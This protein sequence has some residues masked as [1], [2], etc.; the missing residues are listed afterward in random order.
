MSA[1]RAGTLLGDATGASLDDVS[2]A[3]LTPWRD[4]IRRLDMDLRPDLSNLPVLLERVPLAIWGQVLMA[5]DK[6][7]GRADVY[8]PVM[9]SAAVQEAWTGLSGAPLLRQSIAFIN[10]V[11]LACAEAG[12]TPSSALTLDF[13]VGWGR[14]AMLW[15]KYVPPQRLFGCDAW[16]ESLELAKSARLPIELIQSDPFLGELPV[17][18]G[19][20]DVVYSFSVF[21]SLGDVAF[22]R[23]LEGIAKMLRPG[24]VAL[25]TVR[26]PEYW[27]L[28]PDVKGAVQSAEESDF[29]FRPYADKPQYG[30]V[31][32]SLDFL[33]K[34][35]A[36]V[37]MGRPSLEW[38]P[39]DPHQ[40]VVRARRLG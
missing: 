1:A 32:V 22:P 35:C 13:G 29:F 40:V 11:A 15:L 5:P 33:D 39:A 9:P 38:F 28:R 21:T 25:F 23:C 30:D 10:Q 16:P 24:G 26:P 8:L 17:E 12:I 18:V 3:R 7:L 36:E 14:L 4:E 19:S 6:L 37:G 2:W 20:L 31:S 27:T 34:T